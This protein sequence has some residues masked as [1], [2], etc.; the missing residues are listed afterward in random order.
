MPVP[1]GSGL[2]GDGQWIQ[3]V[4]NAGY[5]LC[6]VN[7]GPD[8]VWPTSWVVDT[9]TVGGVAT[10]S[11]DREVPALTAEGLS[12]AYGA[13]INNTA[14][15]RVVGYSYATGVGG[16]GAEAFIWTYGSSTST[17]L[18]TY[19]ANLNAANLSGWNFQ[20][21]EGINNKGEVVGYGTYNG[22]PSAFA[23][24]DYLM[25]GDANGDGKVDINDL[26]VVLTNYGKTGMSWSQGCM[27]GDPTGTVDINDLT[28]VL[29]NYGSVYDSSL[30]AAPE[31]S[32]LLLIASALLGLLARTWRRK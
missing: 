1:P 18:N 6:S 4:N 24:L 26:T 23:L 20:Y 30:A 9:S 17:D 29:S 27:D 19:A 28:I 12:Y 2:V 5:A 10:A 21:A 8:G 22:T 25:P 15:P 16:T 31:P 7:M 32:A 11:Y 3:A 14:T 13:A